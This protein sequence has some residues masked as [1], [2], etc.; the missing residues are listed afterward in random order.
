MLY[1]YEYVSSEENLYSALVRYIL[2]WIHIL[3]WRVWLVRIWIVDIE[4][5]GRGSVVY[6]NKWGLV[7]L[8]F[9]VKISMIFGFR[10]QDSS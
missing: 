1:E 9:M 5:D 3:C 8:G 4:M 10:G 6:M 2:G 7:F